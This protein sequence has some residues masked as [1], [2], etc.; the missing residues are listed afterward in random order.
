MLK[1]FESS[2]HQQKMYTDFF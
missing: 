1:G 2:L